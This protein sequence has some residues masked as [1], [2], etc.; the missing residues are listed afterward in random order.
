MRDTRLMG[1]ITKIRSWGSPRPPER[2]EPANSKQPSSKHCKKCDYVVLGVIQE[3]EGGSIGEDRK[4]SFQ[5]LAAQC[6]KCPRGSANWF[7]W[8]DGTDDGKGD[9]Y[10]WG[11]P[12][13]EPMGMR[14]G[15]IRE[16]DPVPELRKPIEY[17]PVFDD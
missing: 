9:P 16:E 7:K 15:S 10:W 5:R 13:G 6:S 4:P 2:A 1:I 17:E 3:W 14:T 8:I 12:L 11:N